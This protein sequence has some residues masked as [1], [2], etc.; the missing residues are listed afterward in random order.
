[1]VRFRHGLGWYSSLIAIK[2]DL[3][4]NKLCYVAPRTQVPAHRSE[5]AVPKK[6]PG[7]SFNSHDVVSFAAQWSKASGRTCRQI[8]GRVASSKVIERRHYRTVSQVVSLNQ[9]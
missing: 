1:M 2:R 3:T 8:V 6:I 7:H 5:Q 4:R 9:G